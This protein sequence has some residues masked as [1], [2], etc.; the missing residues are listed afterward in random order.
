MPRIL[1]AVVLCA[2]SS[3]PASVTAESAIRPYVGFGIS[4]GVSSTPMEGEFYYLHVD[5]VAQPVH[6]FT[7]LAGEVLLGATT[8]LGNFVLGLDADLDLA[9]PVTLGYGEPFLANISTYCP[10]HDRD[11]AYAS[12]D[13]YFNTLGHARAMVGYAIDSTLLVFAGAGAALAD[14]EV[15]GVSAEISGNGNGAA[16]SQE[17]TP[18][19]SSRHVGLSVNLGAQKQIGNGISIRAEVIHDSYSPLDVVTI[20]NFGIGLDNG[21]EAGLAP[22]AVALSRTAVRTSVVFAF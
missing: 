12:A 3:L 21:T 10:D 15:L 6:G 19:V 11:C 5:G 14:V 9:G 1:P 16:A 18:A 22:D 20:K 17:I 2:L 13:G 4:G 8:Q 7:S